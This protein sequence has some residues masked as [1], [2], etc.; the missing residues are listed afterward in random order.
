MPD[1]PFGVDPSNYFEEAAIA[2]LVRLARFRAA[3]G[4]YTGKVGR[5]SGRLLRRCIHEIP[6]SP[7]HF[8]RLAYTRDVG[9]HTG[10]WWKNPDYERCQ[11]LSL[12]YWSE[13][14]PIEPDRAVSGMLARAFWPDF[15]RM[16][17]IEGPV[18]PEGKSAHVWHYRVFCDPAWQPIMPR[19]EVY[20]RE[21]TE[22]G[23]RTFSEIHG[24]PLADVDAPFLLAGSQ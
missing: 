8:V 5:E 21:Y 13:S 16:A 9:H 14:I 3:Q 20:S 11:H 22:A 7:E 17:W 23:Y 18:S 1:D 6:L 10:G 19:G 12:S 24:T 15:Y 2:K 4:L